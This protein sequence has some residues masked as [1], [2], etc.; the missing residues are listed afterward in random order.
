M[1]QVYG[2]LIFSGYDTSRF[3]ENTASF[4]MADDVTRDLV[5]ALQSISYSGSNSATLLSNSINI[6]IDSTDPNL[7]LP[8]D[9]VDAFES[10]FGLTL[11]NTT[12]LYLINETYHNTLLNENA[13]V[14]FRISD[15]QSG[16]DAVPITLPYAAFDLQAQ[17][18]LVANTSYYF[19]LKRANSSTQYTL[20]RTFLQEAYVKIHSVYPFIN[21]NNF[22][23]IFLQT[24]SV[25]YLTCPHVYGMRALSRTSSPSHLRAPIR[26]QADQG[27]VQGER[28]EEGVVALETRAPRKAHTLVAAP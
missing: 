10:A 3:Q 24:T 15:V 23:V 20:G 28:Q 14:T 7:W 18:P 8:D 2:Q 27:E 17:Y 11:D 13:Q 19:P 6:F 25:K 12:G 1:K 26:P 21:T 4:T 9:V 5:V 16:G 22:P